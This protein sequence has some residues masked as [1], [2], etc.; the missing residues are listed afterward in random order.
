MYLEKIWVEKI[1]AAAANVVF[2][3]FGAGGFFLVFLI[4]NFSKNMIF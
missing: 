2:R 3:K 4:I 1:D